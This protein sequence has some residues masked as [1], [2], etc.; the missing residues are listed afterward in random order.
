MICVNQEQQQ[1]AAVGQQQQQPPPPPL[2]SAAVPPVF[3]IK[4]AYTGTATERPAAH[5]H[6]VDDNEDYS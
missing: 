4:P 1:L 5:K 3:S 6:L 2:F